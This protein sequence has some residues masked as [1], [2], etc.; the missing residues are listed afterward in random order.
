MQTKLNQ[1][2]VFKR[3]FDYSTIKGELIQIDVHNAIKGVLIKR[4][5]EVD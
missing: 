3:I 1:F 5:S 2:S 4:N